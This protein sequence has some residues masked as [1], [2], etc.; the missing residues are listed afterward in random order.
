ML[1]SLGVLLFAATA[2]ALQA[3]ETPDPPVT[4]RD[5]GVSEA[6]QSI[7]IPPVLDAPFAATVHTVWIKTMADGGSVTMVNQR[8]VARDS[9]GRIYQERS[10]FAPQGG[11]IPSQI[12]YVQIVYPDTHVWYDCFLLSQPH[13]CTLED[14]D[15]SPTATYKPAIQ[16]S[17]PLPNNIGVSTH[18]DLGSRSIEGIETIGTRDSLKYNPGVFGNSKSIAVTREFWYAESLST[19]L[20]SE[21]SDP[22]TGK[23]I[24]T[25]TD[26]SL[27][28]PDPRLFDLPEG[29]AIL[30]QRRPSGAPK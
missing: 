2:F 7:F 15:L 8:H 17:G 4:I 24:F 18:E 27:G 3:Q 5:G 25:L 9:R 28:E 30:D 20:I 12:T 1:K 22:R 26:I 19:N 6:L 16:T 29:F 10:A 23:Q 11:N 14:Y 13:T 21:L